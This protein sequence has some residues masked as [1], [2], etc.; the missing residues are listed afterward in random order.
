MS[1]AMLKKIKPES[2][3][4]ICSIKESVLLSYFELNQRRLLKQEGFPNVELIYING[5]WFLNKKDI[6]AY[7]FP[8][9]KILSAV[10]LVEERAADYVKFSEQLRQK[11]FSKILWKE[12]IVDY[13]KMCDQWG[14][15]MR[16]IDIPIYFP[17]HFEKKMI[18]TLQQHGFS[19]KDFDILSY[20]LYNTYHLRRSKD[21]LLLKL[22][23]ISLATFKKKWEWSNLELSRYKALT[24]KFITGQLRTMKNPTQQLA[25]LLKNHKKG[26]REFKRL[27][28]RLPKEL[29]KKADISQKLLYIRDYRF[30]QFI[31]GSFN[32]CRLLNEVAKRLN[33]SYGELIHLTPEEVKTKK[34]PAELQLRRQKYVYIGNKIYT[35]KKA[36]LII[37]LFNQVPKKKNQVSGK[38]VSA[39]V[40]RGRAKVVLTTKEFSKVEK[41]D[42]IV[43]EIT[44]PDYMPVLHKVSA[45]VA[46]IGGFTSHSAIVAREMKIP[47]VVGTEIATKVFKDDDLIEVDADKGTV[48]K[49]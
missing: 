38:G 3:V 17:S 28:Q 27:Y 10:S 1:Q 24:N 25:T 33:L 2:Y 45:I 15:Y 16:V 14:R 42:I 20:P 43:C 49:L 13:Q 44:T 21:F 8:D 41:G 29:K 4:R 22:G 19:E 6:A 9:G 32:F 48:K 30:E 36:D 31:R 23:R 5:Q 26:E 47:C 40:V 12:L 34:I 18:K 11:D 37:Q 39:G 7:D 46:D 35:G